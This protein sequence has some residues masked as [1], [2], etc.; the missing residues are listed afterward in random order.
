MIV[1]SYCCLK[2]ISTRNRTLFK[3]LAHNYKT[4]WQLSYKR[5]PT[6]ETN[7][8]FSWRR[9]LCLGILVV[10]LTVL[11]VLLIDG[12]VQAY[13][14][15]IHSK[16]WIRFFKWVSWFGK[17]EWELIPTALIILLCWFIPFDKFTRRIKVLLVNLWQLALLVLAPVVA[18]GLT[19]IL[20]KLVAQR[21]RP[22]NKMAT[23]NW[24]S[25][26]SI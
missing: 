26:H 19:I 16:P 1:C 7:Y 11:S 24:I 2:P 10:I 6:I 17:S 20:L 4:F 25:F 22:L 15:D 8:F 23:V 18:T 3:T 5:S 21:P 14:W 13:I 9:L 12:P